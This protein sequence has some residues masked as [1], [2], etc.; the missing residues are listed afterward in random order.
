MTARLKNCL[1]IAAVAA[2]ALVP[3]MI[4]KRPAAGPD[5]R[6]IEIFKGTDDRAVTAIQTLAPDYKPWFTSLYTAP[7]SATDTLLFALQAAIGTGFIGYYV[8]YSRKR[9][10]SSKPAP[11]R[12]H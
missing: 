3:L 8:V 5:G 9:T 12:A 1:L 6:P 11:E 4:I 7:G 2:L 10:T